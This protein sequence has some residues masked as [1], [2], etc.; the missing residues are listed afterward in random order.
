LI[1][2]KCQTE[3]REGA[4]FCVQCAATLTSEPV[5]PECG[6]TNPQG[7]RFCEE[8]AHS[9]AEP[10]PAPP[11]APTP[12]PDPTSFANGR[13]QV[14]KLLGE[15]GKKKVYLAHDTHLDRDIAF[16]LI[17]TEGLDA[18]ARARITREARAMGRLGD[19]PGIVTIYEY[20]DHEGQPYLVLP[21][22]PGGDVEGIIEEA[23]DHRL[24]IEQ[25]VAIARSVCQELEF[26]HSKNIIHRDLKPGNV[27]MA[28]DGSAKLGDFGLAVATD[29]SR[30]TQEAK[31]VGTFHYMPP[32][33]ATGGEV[34]SKSDLYSL[35]AMLYEIVTG[36]PPFVGDD[37]YAVV[38]GISPSL[39]A[40]I[41]HLL[42]KDP[43]K[44]PDSA[45]DVLRVL[46]SIEAGK[47][48]DTA[49]EARWRTEAPTT[50][51]CSLAGSRS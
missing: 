16:A 19:H 12:S 11:T 5:C 38:G 29:V 26:A 34:T 28:A 10:A 24:P 1:C 18:E 6:H 42:E 36:R 39:E 51:G 30:L 13:Y 25:A 45:G 20:G 41:M 9:L 43:A 3:N 7:S 32:E 31:M 46:E 37:L 4:K 8:C 33:Q 48:A 22:M 23:P 40:L 44:R 14:K 15:G 35:G 21:L 47:V 27:W 17:K 50:R 49:Q 2:P